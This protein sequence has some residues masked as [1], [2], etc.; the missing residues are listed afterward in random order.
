MK[1]LLLATLIALVGC[2]K[3][4]IERTDSLGPPPPAQVRRLVTLAP[5]LTDLALSLGAKEQIVGVTRYDDA[6]EVQQLTRI[7]GYSDPSVETI[8]R[9]APD[10]VL[11]QPSPGNKGAVE[12]L[13]RT[14]IAIQIFPLESMADVSS[15][16]V[17]IG[18]L[19]ARREAARVAVERIDAARQRAREA[20]ARR[21][22]H[23]RVALLF[24]VSPIVAAGPGS[25]VDELLA[26]AGA[27][28]VVER[29]PQPFPTLPREAL[30]ARKPD[31]VLL[32]PMAV[33]GTS[34]EGLSSSLGTDATELRS[35]GFVR[36]GPRVVEALDELTQLLDGAAGR[37]R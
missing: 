27:L 32:A 4:R 11:C 18:R 3:T 23:P 1:R 14:G 24:D 28:N 33:H 2:S 17:R 7:G 37:I 10:L 9:L 6:A 25:Y 26:D 20:A 13:A 30:L 31:H 22:H 16:L 21:G 5:S 15:A 19:L 8:L 12:Q 36:P 29:A 34:T 35:I